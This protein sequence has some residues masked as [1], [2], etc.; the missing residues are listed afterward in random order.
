MIRDGVDAVWW[1]RRNPA[2]SWRPPE[3]FVDLFTYRI[4]LGFWTLFVAR[5][6]RAGDILDRAERWRHFADQEQRWAD[7]ERHLAAREARLQAEL[8]AAQRAIRE[9][10]DLPLSGGG[11]P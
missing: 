6:T 7:R 2:P 9:Q 4:H 1:I 10:I 3:A 11:A 8:E 5:G